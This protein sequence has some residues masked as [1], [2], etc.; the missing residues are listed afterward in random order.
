MATV[1]ASRRP[2]ASWPRSINREQRDDPLLD[3]VPAIE[4]DLVGAADGVAD[5]LFE[6]I[7]GLVELAQQEGLLR[8]LRDRA[9]RR[10]RCGC[11][12]CRRYNRPGAPARGSASGCAGA[13][14]SMPNSS[15][16]LHRVGARRLALH[17]AQARR[18]DTV[19]APALDGVA[20]QPLGHG[21]AANVAGA[22]KK[23]GLHLMSQGARS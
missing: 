15:Q 9:T 16:G 2:R 4:I 13:E 5:V 11:G 19:I 10:F 12:S 22:N 7:Q 23:D 21:A 18:E 3:L 1:L 17:R 6:E 14:I 20:K 8:R